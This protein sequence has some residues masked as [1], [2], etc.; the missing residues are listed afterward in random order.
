M[1]ALVND[2]VAAVVSV[3]DS[4][5]RWRRL[6]EEQKSVIREKNRIRVAQKRASLSEHQ[7]TQRLEVERQKAATRRLMESPMRRELRKE[8]QRFRAALRRKNETPEQ[9]ELRL[10]IGREKA[11][12]RRRNETPVSREKRLQAG[13]ERVA[14]KRSS[15]KQSQGLAPDGIGALTYLGSPLKQHPTAVILDSSAGYEPELRACHSLV[16]YTNIDNTLISLPSLT[17]ACHLIQTH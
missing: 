13:R 11:N 4:P 2:S 8:K 3:S 1:E 12:E 7:K 17:S 15:R 6:S 16:H 9:R 5:N 10:R 14:M